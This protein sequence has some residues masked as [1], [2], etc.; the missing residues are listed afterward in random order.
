VSPG[1]AKPVLVQKM[2]VQKPG[3]VQ[4]QLPKANPELAMGKY[5]WSVTLLCESADRYSA[6]PYAQ[7]WI[8]RVAAS[9]EQAKQ[10]TA[11]PSDRA[12]AQVYAESGLWYDALATLVTARSA[13]PSDSAIGADLSALLNQVGLSQVAKQAQAR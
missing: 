10:A 5:R 11:A 1:V 9:P 6:R 2:Q 12:L 3:L 7:S 8:E 4:L 13:N